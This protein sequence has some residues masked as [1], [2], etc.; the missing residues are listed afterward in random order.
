MV[1]NE[2]FFSFFIS[3]ILWCDKWLCHQSKHFV[4][5]I[6]IEALGINDE[7]FFFLSLIVRCFFLSLIVCCEKWLY[8][9]R[10]L[11]FVYNFV[12]WVKVYQ[13]FIA[14]FAPMHGGSVADSHDSEGWNQ[15][16]NTDRYFSQTE[17]YQEDNNKWAMPAIAQGGSFS[18]HL[19]FLSVYPQ[20]SFCFNIVFSKNMFDRERLSGCFWFNAPLQ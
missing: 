12:L 10:T 9:S 1:I 20:Y 3:L 11:C 13:Y 5:K 2:E 7:F 15:P 18:F 17:R 14:A 8:D 19:T 6:L 4:F 16:L